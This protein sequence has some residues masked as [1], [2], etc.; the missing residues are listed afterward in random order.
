MAYEINI[1]SE[2]SLFKATEILDLS[3]FY[4]FQN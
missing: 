1:R 2:I 3:L 4:L